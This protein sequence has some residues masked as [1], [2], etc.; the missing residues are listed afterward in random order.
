MFPVSG[1]EV[2]HLLYQFLT[3]SPVARKLVQSKCDF[4]H[5][6]W[7][8]QGQEEEF[9]RK[10]RFNEEQIKTYVETHRKAYESLAEEFGLG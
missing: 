4:S 8:A 10:S 5:L 7:P 1:I 2:P 9:V 6:E 3:C